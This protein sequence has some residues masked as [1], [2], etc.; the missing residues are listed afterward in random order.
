MMVLIIGGS[1]SG[2]SA[3]AEEY[4]TALS[5][6]CKKYYLATMQVFDKEG[7]EKVKRHRRMRSGRGFFTIEQPVG[8]EDALLKIEPESSVLLECISNLTANEM[9]SGK[10]MRTC[11]EVTK[12]VVQGIRELSQ[13]VRHLVIVTNNVFED[14]TI[15]DEPTMEYLRAMGRINEKLAAMADKVVEVVAGIPIVIKG[16]D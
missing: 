14:G 10:I 3:Y 16:G 11:Q 1:G 2:K 8:I 9:F 5:K 4:I 12:S 7:Q 13:E 15:Y 6:D